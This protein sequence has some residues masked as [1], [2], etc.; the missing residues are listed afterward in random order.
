M[1][2]GINYRRAIVNLLKTAIPLMNQGNGKPNG[3]ASE[4][5]SAGSSRAPTK[6]MCACICRVGVP[7]KNVR[8]A[9]EKDFAR[10][11]YSGNGKIKH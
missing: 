7:T 9:T 2:L 6:C 1:F 10:N 5:F 4:D 11:P 8:N 3:M